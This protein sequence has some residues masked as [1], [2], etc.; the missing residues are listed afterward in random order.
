M[1]KPVRRFW[2]PG[3]NLS[4]INSRITHYSWS[5]GKPEMEGR[6]WYPQHHHLLL[7]AKSLSTFIFLLSIHF[8]SSLPGTLYTV[9]QVVHCTRVLRDAEI[10]PILHVLSCETAGLHLLR[11]VAFC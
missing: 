2:P 5:F 1:N 7:L 11:R 9:G 10:Y 6:K 3:S 8:A 4:E